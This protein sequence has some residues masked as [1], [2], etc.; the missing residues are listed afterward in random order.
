MNGLANSV[1]LLQ[2]GRV[3]FGPGCAVSAAAEM[4]SR[5]CKRVAL[6]AS[7]RTMRAL[8]SLLTELQAQSISVVTLSGIP[9]EPTSSDFERVRARLQ[10]VAIDA[11]LA[12]GGGSVLDIG[13]LLAALHGRTEPVSAFYG[14]GLL[15]LRKIGLICLPT[16]SGSGSE[17]SPNAILLDESAQLKKGVISPQLV[18]DAAYIDPVLTTSMPGELTAATGMDALV[19]CIEAYANLKAHPIVDVY[20]LRGIELIGANLARAVQHGDDLAA[21]SAVALGSLYGGLCLGPVN[22]AA[23]HALAYP[24]GSMYRIAHGLANALMLPHVLR[25][26]LPAAPERYAAIARALGVAAAADDTR[27]AAEAGVSRIEQLSRECGLPRSLRPLGLTPEAVPT[28]VAGAM[29]V[30]RL[31]QNN[32]RPIA[33]EDAT[34][35]FNSA[36]Q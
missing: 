20:A 10:G 25:F 15:P 16:T 22:T 35:I 26:N 9:P 8:A 19:H 30:T 6:V 11:V 28:L 13:K 33:P 3:V 1:T 5:G 17:V 21:R 4:A 36:L 24:L 34:A 18:P 23:V 27:T 31:L 12:A 7:E 14:T 29:Q 32:V 2:P